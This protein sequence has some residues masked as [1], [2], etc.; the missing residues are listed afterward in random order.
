MERNETVVVTTAAD[1]PNVYFILPDMM[2]GE[3]LFPRFGLGREMVAELTSYGFETVDNAYSNAPV[4]GFSMPHIFGMNYVVEDGEQ[5]TEAKMH[6]LAKAFRNNA[7]YTEFKKRG[8]KIVLIDDGYWGD[9]GKGEDRCI[10]KHGGDRYRRQDIR[11]LERTPF[12]RALEVIDLELSLFDSPVSLWA[13]PSR[14]EVP[15]IISRLSDLPE[16]AKFVYIHL[17]LPHYPFRFGQDCS[18]QQFEVPAIAYGHQLKCTT[19]LLPGLI[20]AIIDRDPGA[21]IVAQSDHGIS[22]DGQ[23]LKPVSELSEAEIRTNL[24]IFS[25]FR[26]PAD[27]PHRPRPGLTPVNTFRLVFACLDKTQPRLLEDRMFLVY[28]LSWPSGGKVR[29]W[30]PN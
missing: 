22:F 24:S 29:E 4:T 11:F 30:K 28:Y 1:T 2:V 19:K 14:M 7:V 9:C 3:E 16:G 25:A 12:M 6:R 23:H 15:E 20:R 27:C 8:Y 26:L 21:I 18:Y 5:V 10:R 13:Y 17:A